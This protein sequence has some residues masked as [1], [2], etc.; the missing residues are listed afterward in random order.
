M[1]HRPIRVLALL[2]LLAC[3]NRDKPAAPSP[4]PSQTPV[5]AIADAHIADAHEAGGDLVDA[6]PESSVVIAEAGAPKADA[7]LSARG[8][9]EPG[10]VATTKLLDP[11]R[12]PRRKMRY[13][14]SPTE[15]EQFHLEVKASAQSAAMTDAGKEEWMKLPPWAVTLALTPQK[16]S[17]DGELTYAFLLEK[18]DVPE[19]SGIP[20]KI[21]DGLK[22][23]FAAAKGLSGTAKINARGITT[24]ASFQIPTGAGPQT[25]QMVEQMRQAIRDV[26]V[27]FPEE[28]I[29]KGA[30]W[31]KITRLDSAQ[32]K[33]TQTEVFTLTEVEG[34]LGK[35]SVAI[36]QNAPGQ[37]VAGPE[38]MSL[39][40]EQMSAT[41]KGLWSFD[42]SRIV[43]NSHTEATTQMTMKGGPHGTPALPVKL[44]LELTT[45]GQK[46]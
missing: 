21:R 4:T 30:K 12:E 38:G 23:Q 3:E 15:K 26:A 1:L 28:D 43:S 17:G 22:E 31:Q 9:A 39:R 18:V 6:G 37:N 20:S 44:R 32:A 29:G 33:I 25:A 13:T 7:G 5:P 40:M 11:G 45:E 27:A 24:D 10:L 35:V 42:L 14:F 46:P 8:M 16:V 34:N 19:V 36:T 41:G 2:L